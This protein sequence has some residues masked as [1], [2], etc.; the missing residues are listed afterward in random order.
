M[1]H[2]VHI[3]VYNIRRVN[4]IFRAGRQRLIRASYRHN[5]L[6]SKFSCCR[7]SIIFGNYQDYLLETR[8]FIQCLRANF[9]LYFIDIEEKAKESDQ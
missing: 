7:S 5:D 3:L 2:R 4:G 6:V 9:Q 1:Y 8:E